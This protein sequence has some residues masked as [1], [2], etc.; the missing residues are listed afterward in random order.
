MSKNLKFRDDGTFVIVQFTDTEF[1]DEYDHD[2]ESPLLDE[3]TRRLMEMVIQEEKP[4]L[5]VFTGDIIASARSKDPIQSF[6]RAVSVVEEYEVP[7]AA[8]FGNHDSEGRVSR[9]E[10][11]Q[12]QLEHE[13]N[14]SQMDPPGVSGAGNYTL[15]IADRR[16]KIGAVLYFLD[17]G[18]YSSYGGYD[19]IKRDQ[20]H[21]YATESQA[22]TKENGGAPLP[23]LAFFHI[24]LLE[25]EEAWEKQVS[26]G[27]RLTVKRRTPLLNSG[28]FAALVEMGDVMGT[29][30]G[31][32]HANDY[33]STLYGI[34]LCYGR[35]AK[36][37]S[38]IDNVRKDHFP[39]GARVIQ[40]LEG[41][42]IFNTWIRQNDGTVIFEQPKHMPE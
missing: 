5:V 29:F 23:A 19:W 3:A 10:M 22:F 33:C 12:L 2:P 20:I 25:Y 42:R 35:S 24:P 18:D 34:R 30:V 31:H 7:W 36:Y 6:R 39:T 14:V 11:H 1:I 17:S 8:V 4:D 9:K 15:T 37:I 38:Y 41:E 32:N 26:Y 40:L 27:Q 21:W 28:L 16:G 13:F